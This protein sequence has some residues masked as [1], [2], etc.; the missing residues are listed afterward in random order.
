M[1]G[2]CYIYLR[3]HDIFSLATA[4][5]EDSTKIASDADKLEPKG[6]YCDIR[7]EKITNIL[8]EEPPANADEEEEQVDE[9]ES[10]FGYFYAIKI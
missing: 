4:Y 6:V 8:I 2:K 3:R 7:V 5:A 1:R 10:L 9:P